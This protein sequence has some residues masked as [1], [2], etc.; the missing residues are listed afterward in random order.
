[1]SGLILL[2][3][4]TVLY[5]GYNLFVK[6]SGAQ[7]PAE[8]TTTVLAAISIQLAA[9]ATSGVFL[10]ILMVRGGQ[11]LS[12]SNGT[13]FWAAVAGICIGGA[14]ICYLYLF[15]GVGL[16]KPMDASVAIP[17]IVSGTIVITLLFSYFVLEETISWN[18]MLGSLLIV[19]GI[20]MFFVK[21]QVPG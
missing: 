3:A 2:A 13:Y 18:Q 11:V 15:G 17:T 21:A 5:A 14:E 10:S 16:S 20:I 4:V 19:G 8:A 1:M 6:L 9:L 12:L 7:V